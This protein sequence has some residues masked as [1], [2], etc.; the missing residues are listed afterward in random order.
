MS[1]VTA[2]GPFGELIVLLAA[3]LVAYFSRRQVLQTR[4]ELGKAKV[5]AEAYKTAVLSIRPIGEL[6]QL[7]IPPL[8]IVRT[9]FSPDSTPAARADRPPDEL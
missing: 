4:S 6:A 9:G 3:G 8:P 1:L 2:L 5:E 7:S